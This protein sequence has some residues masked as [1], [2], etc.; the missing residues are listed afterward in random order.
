[1]PL[2][3][4]VYAHILGV[5]FKELYCF[6]IHVK[7]LIQWGKVRYTLIIC[8]CLFSFWKNRLLSLLLWLRYLCQNLMC[9]YVMFFGGSFWFRWSRH[10]I[11]SQDLLAV[12]SVCLLHNLSK[13]DDTRFISLVSD[14]FTIWGSYCFPVN[15]RVII[16]IF[17]KIVTGILVELAVNL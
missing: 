15:F 7:I 5:C 13:C 8:M 1:M 11:Y 14:P 17:L 16:P 9:I 2:T 3:C 4:A 12:I 10:L 6:R